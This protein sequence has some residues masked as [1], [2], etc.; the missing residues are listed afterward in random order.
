MLARDSAG[1]AAATRTAGNSGGDLLK[2]F[3]VTLDYGHQLMWL[4]PNAL[5]ATP[6]L[7][8]RAGLWIMR[9]DDGAIAVADVWG[10]GAAQS[11]GLVTG[12]EIVSIDG[13]KAADVAL[14][15]LREAFKKPSGTRFDLR[16]RDRSGTERSLVL[17][18]AKQV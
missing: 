7:F 10:G 8:D 3:T 5:A 12:D 18:L 2:R 15:D 17:S 1:A 13:R 14:Y 6:D 11:A 4:Q 16:V 9:A